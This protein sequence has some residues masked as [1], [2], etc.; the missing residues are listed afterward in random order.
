LVENYEGKSSL[1][2]L[3]VDGEIILKFILK[4][5][6]RYVLDSSGC[7]YQGPESYGND[8]GFQKMVSIP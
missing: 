8:F 1:G 7:S 3:K 2:S 5:L 4:R 6:E